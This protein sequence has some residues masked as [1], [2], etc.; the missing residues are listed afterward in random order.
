MGRTFFRCKYDNHSN[1]IV[2]NKTVN[3]NLGGL[4]FHIDEDAFQKLN[5]YFDA[6]KR[7][8]SNSSGQDEIMKDI[9]L[10]VSEIFS[11]RQ[12]SE[13]SV[14]SLK[15]VDAMIAV[16]G[17]PEDYRIE[18]E[19]E[20]TSHSTQFKKNKKLYRDID[21]NVLG[22]VAAGFGHYFGVDALW[23][24]LILVF[25]VIAGVGFPIIIYFI[26]W[27]LI[28]KALT[29]TE[30]LEMTG[31]PVNLSNIE[32]K[33]REEFASFSEKVEN[34][35]YE[36]MGSH[37]K[38]GAEKIGSSIG[39]IFMS[40][41]NV[42][43]KII[44]AFIVV[45]SIFT[46]GGLII[47]LFTF[48]ST[49][50]VDMPWQGY[51]DAVI[52]S[53]FPIWLIVI[54]SFF[55][56]GIPFFFLLILGLKLLITNMKS[57]GNVAKYTLLALWLIVVGTLISFGI[58]QATE[59]AH[60]G[61]IVQK[62]ILNY[63]VGDTLEIKFKY[64]E[65]YA[66]SFRNKDFEIIQ[67]ENGNSVIYSNNVRIEI[68]TTDE[69]KPYLLIEK[70]AEGKSLSDAKKRA[71]KINYSF[72]TEGNSLI[73]DNYFVTD[74]KNKFRDQEVELFLYLPKD[75]HFKTDSSVENY[76]RSDNDV[77]NLHFSSKDYVYKMGDI[78][79]TCLNCP[80]D[81]NEYNDVTKSKN[82][83]DTVKTIS[84][85]INDKEILRTE[86]NSKNFK[87]EIDENGIIKKTN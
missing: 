74:L 34:A 9:E 76:D 52:V 12:S 37:V 48:G 51:Y 40:I 19:G 66:K 55:A 47:S 16:M 81:E 75:V 78:K 5:R 63:N 17:Q 14:I 31:E 61:K 84:L 72:R 10:R 68:L 30:K 15:D 65:F 64:N 83:N 57:I 21:N 70:K 46:L 44:G 86:S 71:E 42:F 50:F 54:L 25:L 79:V 73:L 59:V 3:I 38:S 60:D 24:R 18:E 20:P 87:L 56:I 67:D 33:V 45:I 28:P 26:M 1:Q 49:T 43:A 23:I 53:E 8:L 22:G 7:S 41:F 27:V 77:F 2:M 35:D 32:K 11:E 6:I 80:G 39:E 85:K 29:T 13:K 36:K 69:V 4:F 58:K 62:E 82:E